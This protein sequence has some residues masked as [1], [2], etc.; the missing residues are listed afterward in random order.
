MC[1]ST[2]EVLQVNSMVYIHTYRDVSSSS[3][4]DYMTDSA[5]ELGLGLSRGYFRTELFIAPEH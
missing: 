4:E 5:S 2:A 3:P 1:A